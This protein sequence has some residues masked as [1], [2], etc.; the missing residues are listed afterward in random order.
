MTTNLEGTVLET[1]RIAYIASIEDLIATYPAQEANRPAYEIAAASLKLGRL[2]TRV[3]T[4]LHDFP[5]GTIVAT[6]PERPA[7]PEHD[8]PGNWPRASPERAGDLRVPEL[9]TWRTP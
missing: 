8:V 5:A 6:L 1:I 4:K 9:L 3:R 2:K 7:Q